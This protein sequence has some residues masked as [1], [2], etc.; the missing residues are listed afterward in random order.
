MVL[1]EPQH[2]V[3]RQA[4]RVKGAVGASAATSSPEPGVLGGVSQAC[5]NRGLPPWKKCGVI[6]GGGGI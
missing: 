1:C 3:R 6:L 4:W 5:D 2:H